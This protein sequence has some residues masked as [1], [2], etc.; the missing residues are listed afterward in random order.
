M[1]NKKDT[2][3]LPYE[4]T[5]DKAKAR[6]RG[7]FYEFR[8]KSGNVLYYKCKVPI[9]QAIRNLYSQMVQIEG[10]FFY[11]KSPKNNRKEIAN[12]EALLRRLGV[13]EEHVERY[14]YIDRVFLTES[15]T[16]NIS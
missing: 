5:L 8:F 14:W 10:I 2:S 1:K 15:D 16:S 6:W 7:A 13:K 12:K 4:K 11:G 3:Q 9:L